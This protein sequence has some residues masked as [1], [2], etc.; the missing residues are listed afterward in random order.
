MHSMESE[1]NSPDTDPVSELNCQQEAGSTPENLPKSTETQDEK[2]NM[3]GA[4]LHDNSVLSYDNQ[5]RDSLDDEDIADNESELPLYQKYKSVCRC[6][7]DYLH[8]DSDGVSI[9]DYLLPE[10]FFKRFWV[11]DIVTAASKNSCCFTKRYT[12]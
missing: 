10:K 5:T 2:C 11:M 3:I 9:E 12:F 8:K 7:G 6:I 4:N 1:G